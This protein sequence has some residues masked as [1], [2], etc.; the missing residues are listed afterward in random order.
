[1]SSSSLEHKEKAPRLLTFAVVTISTSKHKQKEQGS[2]E[3]EDLSGDLITRLLEE[4][5]HKVS[6][7]KLIPD[8]SGR[9]S[10]ALINILK[11]EQQPVDTVVTTGGTGITKSDITVEMVGRLME[12]E[13]PGF[14]EFFR[15]ISY[16][17][18]G[19]AAILTRAIA[20]VRNG[21]VIFCLPGSPE[22]VETA[23]RNLIIPEAPHIVKH[24]REP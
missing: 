3:V 4:A 1:M 20:G 13:L 8:D 16:E 24:A 14:G 10:T 2:L 9:I 22:A 23:V 19:S 18:I 17:K 15:R 6:L 5:G 21:K 12:K 7:R 11:D